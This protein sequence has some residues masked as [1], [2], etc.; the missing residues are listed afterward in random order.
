MIWGNQ[1]DTLQ[2]DFSSLKSKNGSFQGYTRCNIFSDNI[3]EA[4][5]LKWMYENLGYWGTVMALQK[6]VF[7][8][9]FIDD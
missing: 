6:L 3:P 8:S 7:S 1:S 9:V 4:V 5:Q 2:S